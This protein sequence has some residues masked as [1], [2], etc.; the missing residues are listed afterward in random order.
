MYMKRILLID[1]DPTDIFISKKMLCY[2]TSEK[3]IATCENGR[4]AITYLSEKIK[5]GHPQPD[6]IITDL[7]MPEMDGWEF[8]EEYRKLVPVEDDRSTIWIS[9]Y[10]ASFQDIIKVKSHDMVTGYISKPLR[11]HHMEVLLHE[12]GTATKFIKTWPQYETIAAPS[13]YFFTCHVRILPCHTLKGFLKPTDSRVNL[14][15]GSASLVNL[16]PQ[17]FYIYIINNTFYA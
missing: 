2:D 14:F 5:T 6:L 1:D 3:E 16:I 10:S 9:S 11:L 4:E 8:L 12:K 15:I 17:H 7:Y 13:A